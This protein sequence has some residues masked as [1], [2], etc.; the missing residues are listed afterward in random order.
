MH[1]IAVHEGP[2][3]NDAG[4][5]WS[6]SNESHRAIGRQIAVMAEGAALQQDEDLNGACAKLDPS[7]RCGGAVSVLS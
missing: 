4:P 1:Y 6:W 5:A 2:Q 7:A 3:R